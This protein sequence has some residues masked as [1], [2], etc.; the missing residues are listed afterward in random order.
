MIHIPVLTKEVLELLKP[1]RNEN[2]VDCTIGEGGHAAA[3]LEKNGPEG[4]VLGIDLDPSQ[5][6][7]SRWLETKFKGRIVLANDSYANLQK[8]IKENNFVPINGILLDLGMSSRHIEE[9]KKGFSFKSDQALD[10]RYGDLA[11]DL[12]AEII[13]NEWPED[14]IEEIL[15]EYGEEKFAGRIAKN[16]AEERKRARIKSTF[17]LVEIIRKAIP[18]KM[19]HGRIH[20]ATK[21]F[22]ALRIAVNDELNNLKKVLPDIISVL[23]PG[24]RIAIISFH[25][26]EDRIVKNFF[27]NKERE[28][29]PDGGIEILTKKPLTAGSGELKLNPR[30]RSAKLRAFEKI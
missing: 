14:K 26:L 15:K 3:I 10:M 4:K 23:S 1:G 16:I 7:S 9:L 17:Q 2:F 20:F 13:L 19:Q 25:S 22:Q 11:N 29:P 27:K 6:L 8:I 5:I 30:S 28:N 24:G 12:T 18:L 21:T